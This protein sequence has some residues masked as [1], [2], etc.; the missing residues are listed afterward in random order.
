MTSPQRKLDAALFW[1]AADRHE[2]ANGTTYREIEIALPREL[3]PAQRQEL[4]LD[5]IQQEIGERHAHQWAIHNPGA[6]LAGGE[7][8]HAHLMYSERTIDG[9]ERDPEQYFSATTANTPNLEVAGK[10]A[11]ARK[12]GCWKPGSGG[13]RCKTPICNS[14]ATRRG[15]TTGA[16]RSKASTG[17]PSSTWAGDGCGNWHRNS[18]KSC[19][20]GGTPKT[21][22]SLHL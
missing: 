22:S 21:N 19:W 20:N 18:G 13:P 15:W 2:R 10:T 4:V 9:I 12:N 17:H 8:P 6:A 7:Q 14:T 11:P 1:T 3:N 16:W 5:F